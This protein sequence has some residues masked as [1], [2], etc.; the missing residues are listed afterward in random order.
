MGHL[1]RRLVTVRQSYRNIVDVREVSFTALSLSRIISEKRY[2]V[3]IRTSGAGRCEMEMQSASYFSI[4]SNKSMYYYLV[5][6][7]LQMPYLKTKLIH[8]LE[9][10]IYHVS[11]K[12]EVRAI[13]LFML[14]RVG[15][16]SLRLLRRQS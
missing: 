13:L 15:W 14:F 12:Q 16:K 11:I 5:A 9:D 7:G 1:S 8:R 2:W 4:L 6:L 10:Y 3:Q